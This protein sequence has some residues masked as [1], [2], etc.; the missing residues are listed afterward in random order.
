MTGQLKALSIRISIRVAN[1]P[2][3]MECDTA[4]LMTVANK[5]LLTT[6]LKVAKMD[7]R[8]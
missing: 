4:C 5:G 8:G 3:V 7:I 6:V 1:N 2:E